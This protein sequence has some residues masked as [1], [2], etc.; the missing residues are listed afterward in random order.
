MYRLANFQDDTALSTQCSWSPNAVGAYIQMTKN[1]DVDPPVYW[2]P[3][4]FNV[5]DVDIIRDDGYFPVIKTETGHWIAAFAP[6]RSKWAK[7]KTGGIASNSFAS[8]VLEKTTG[9]APYWTA[10][11]RELTAYN[12][13]AAIPANVLVLLLKI[14]GRWCAFEVC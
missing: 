11:T 10:D 12:R 4:V 1:G 3:R 2:K 9:A 14:D 7:T 6:Y 5:S 13:G 8:V